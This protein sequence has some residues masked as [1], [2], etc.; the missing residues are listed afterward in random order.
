MQYNLDNLWEML[1]SF[2]INASKSEKPFLL[3][4]VKKKSALFSTLSEDQV[5]SFL[6]YEES[7]SQLIEAE[8]KEAFIKG[9]K[10]ATQFLFEASK[11]QFFAVL[12]VGA[13][14]TNVY[15]S[16]KQSLFFVEST[17]K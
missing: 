14:L 16:Q 15:L 7:L 17:R 1:E 10:F 12:E 2:N 11:E 5:Q 8:R 3:I 13:Y 6:D 9:I 4:E